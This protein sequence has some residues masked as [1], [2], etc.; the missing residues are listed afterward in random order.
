[1]NAMRIQLDLRKRE[2]CERFNQPSFVQSQEP[3]SIDMN[4][5]P[6]KPSPSYTDAT[7]QF[8][9]PTYQ[10]QEGNR[11]N[12]HVVAENKSQPFP[13][14][15]S[16]EEST[17]QLQR[18]Y[19]INTVMEVID[20]HDIDDIVSFESAEPSMCHQPPTYSQTQ[21]INI[22]RPNAPINIDALQSCFPQGNFMQQ[23]TVLAAPA[24]DR[25]QGCSLSSSPGC[26]P[27][28]RYQGE[29][30][31]VQSPCQQSHVQQMTCAPTTQYSTNYI[32]E[33][34]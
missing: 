30:S 13:P 31:H 1:M 25:M 21:P 2:S 23:D 19:S 10:R 20:S 11:Y 15:P 8:N 34:K 26:L 12:S 28:T 18:Q 6:M 3:Q 17:P 14:Q 9:F 29:V 5:H 7:A 24:S 22:Q 32:S 33:G 4:A 27:F 16:L